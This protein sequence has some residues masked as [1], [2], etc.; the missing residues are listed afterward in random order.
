MAEVQSPPER[1]QPRLNRMVTQVIAIDFYD[2]IARQRAAKVT[3]ETIA[4][5]LTQA[6][7]RC[8]DRTLQKFFLLEKAKRCADEKEK[9]TTSCAAA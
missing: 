9:N 2:S 7:H 3:F 1:P 5:L 6:G 4:R 8:N